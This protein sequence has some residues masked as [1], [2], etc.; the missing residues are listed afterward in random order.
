M[1]YYFRL[2]PFIYTC[3]PHNNKI[4]F[5]NT[6]NSNYI[7]YHINI[8]EQLILS[9]SILSIRSNSSN[10]PNL[11]SMLEEKNMGVIIN[12]SSQ[13]FSLDMFQRLSHNYNELV[14]I[15]N[16]LANDNLL[17]HL[18]EI[19]F[20]FRKLDIPSLNM[21]K[22]SKQYSLFSYKHDNKYVNYS[23]IKK[24]LSENIYQNLY[25]INYVG[26]NGNDFESNII[27]IYE[28]TS[29]YPSNI[30]LPY[31]KYVLESK[32]NPPFKYIVIC[33][34][35]MIN[36]F[37][38]F[39]NNIERDQ[40]VIYFYIGS[41][42]DYSLIS[43]KLNMVNN[44]NYKIFTYQKCNDN[45]LNNNV[46]YSVNELL[47]QRHSINQIIRSGIINEL[48]YGKI[49]IHNNGEVYSNVQQKS[50]GNI[51]SQKINTLLYKASTDKS[52]WMLT[53][54]N[55]SCCKECLF[56]RICPPI[57][58]IEQYTSKVYCIK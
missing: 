28:E 44:L 19:T 4:L 51:K 42:Y 8:E 32:S 23:L 17:N 7:I 35:Q 53:R 38:Y 33:D 20:C 36:E 52:S 24:I 11:I 48:Y 31:S 12:G 10:I 5:Y 56:K 58:E 40:V 14:N 39:V 43:S 18:F 6:L 26:I 49:T 27:P 57:S 55:Y 47:S 3:G 15:H 25:S 41:E 50:L 37:E 45:F 46:K 2:D 54:D 21:D 9:N 34:N 22:I 1:F 29:Y 30:V 13:V 16:P